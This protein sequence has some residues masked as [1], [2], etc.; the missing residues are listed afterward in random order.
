MASSPPP[1]VVLLDDTVDD[2]TEIIYIDP[3]TALPD[4]G[5]SSDARHVEER[6]ESIRSLRSNPRYRPSA[7]SPARQRAEDF[8]LQNCHVLFDLLRYPGEY[9]EEYIRKTKPGLIASIREYEHAFQRDGQGRPLNLLFSDKAKRR[10]N[11]EVVNLQ[12][13]AVFTRYEKYLPKE[14]L[15]E[16]NKDVGDQENEAAAAAIS[17]PWHRQFWRAI[18]EQLQLEEEAYARVLIGQAYHND[19]PTSL[20]LARICHNHSLDQDEM[21]ALIR[22]CVFADADADAELPDAD[23]TK[24]IRERNFHGLAKRLAT[25]METITLGNLDD[26]MGV[27]FEWIL[28]AIETVRN[29]LFDDHGG[30]QPYTTWAPKKLLWKQYRILKGE[31]KKKKNEGTPLTAL[32]KRAFNSDYD[33]DD[34]DYDYDDD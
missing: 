3:P 28:T 33:S 12:K 4:I 21:L 29:L 30:D 15:S 13:V 11:D 34:D 17:D 22:H 27:D 31:K 16:K 18:H 10:L 9:T 5:D 6:I 23:L 7:L 26:V 25:D 32:V 24:F 19:C 2:F 20:L 1:V 14:Y 8:Y